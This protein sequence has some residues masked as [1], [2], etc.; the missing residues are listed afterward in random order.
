MIER[1]EGTTGKKLLLTTLAS[2]T[3]ING[4]HEIASEL[5]RSIQLVELKKGDVLISQDGQDNDLFFIISGSLNIEV[6]RRLVA[7]RQSGT[8]VGEMAL[9]DGKAKRCASVKAGELSVVAKVSHAVF[10]K[11]ADKHPDLWRRMAM[12][13][14][15][16]LRG[17]NSSIRHRNE[18]P[19][20]F[21]CS[22]SE[23]HAVA[24]AI[25]RGLKPFS[26]IVRVWTDGVFR[27]S[28]YT[29]EDLEREVFESDFAVAVIADDDVVRSRK[30][31]SVA[32]RDNVIFELGL[33]MGQLGRKRT[34]MVMP[35]G[36]MLKIP[37]DLFGLNPIK[38][39]PP[40]DT[41]NKRQWTLALSPVCVELKAE[42]ERQACR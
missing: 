3:I 37:S 41:T 4:D 38:Y 25:Q 42:I 33:F 40:S 20:I 16:R 34:F 30:S 21:I 8:H 31:Q 35:K 36:K 22:S 29:L 17:R 24:K 39:V 10:A 1:F 6:N 15:D 28:Q 7:V 26:C 19:Q 18:L 2:Q 11:T 12:E 13:L 23:N 9:I 32:P 14:C 5:F 27:P